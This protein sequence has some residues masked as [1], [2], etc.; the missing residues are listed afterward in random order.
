MILPTTALAIYMLQLQ[1]RRLTLDMKIFW[2]I[3]DQL[4]LGA[5]AKHVLLV[6]LL[7]D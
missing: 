4:Q 6:K 7:R 2:L 5:R 1:V 3:G